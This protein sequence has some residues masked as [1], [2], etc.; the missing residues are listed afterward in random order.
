M[1]KVTFLGHPVALSGELPATGKTAPNFSGLKGDLTEVQLSDYR[2]KR[3]VLNIFP[4]LDTEVCAASVRRFNKEAATAPNAVVLCISKDLPFAQSRFCTVEG[5]ENVQPLSLFRHPA[6][7]ADYG[8]RIE[9]GPLQG[10]LARAVIVLDEQGRILYT[11]RVSEI[12]HEPD[13]TA[14]IAALKQAQEG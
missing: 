12:T 11:E 13:Y 8:L 5:L 4:S 9:E 2:G 7:D 3:V 10:L 14:A 1:S 6:F